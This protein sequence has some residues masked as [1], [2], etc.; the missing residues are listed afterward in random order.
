GHG[1][2]LGM[3]RHSAN[4]PRKAARPLRISFPFLSPQ[5]RRLDVGALR[6]SPSESRHQA[7]LS[8]DDAV[9]ADSLAEVASTM[10]ARDPCRARPGAAGSEWARFSWPRW[11]YEAGAPPRVG[12]RG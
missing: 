8:V 12:A 3:G 2:S 10:Q 7:L 5:R 9:D 11:P 1:S 4:A 6:A